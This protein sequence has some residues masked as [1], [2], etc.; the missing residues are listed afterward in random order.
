[1]RAVVRRWSLV[2][3]F[4]F[5]LSASAVSNPQVPA[6]LRPEVKRHIDDLIGDLPANSLLGRQLANGAHGSGIHQ[7]W[8]DDMRREK[9]KRAI[10]WISIRFDRHGKPK[11]MRVEQIEYFAQYENG[12]RVPGTGDLERKLSNDALQNAANGFWGRA[13]SKATL[14]CWICSR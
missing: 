12:E 10:V 7:A 1:M 8:M 5:A 3:G 4:L 11:H 9:I 2:V 13:A 6:D 14:V